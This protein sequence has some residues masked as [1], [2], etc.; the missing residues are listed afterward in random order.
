MESIKHI[1]PKIY[2]L[3]DNDKEYLLELRQLYLNFFSNLIIQYENLLKEEKKK[4]L[5]VM[6]HKIKPAMQY[7]HLQKL[8]DLLNEGVLMLKNTT[9][10]TEKMNE[11]IKKVIIFCEEALKEIHK[12]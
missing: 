2:E 9:N 7:L 8:E 1:L 11:N 4:E 6:I 5:S 10:S 12:I 3:A